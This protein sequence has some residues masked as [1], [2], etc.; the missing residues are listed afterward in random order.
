MRLL[1]KIFVFN[2]D[3]QVLLLQRSETD[4]HRP[5]GWDLP[6]GGVELNENPNVTVIRELKEE[7]GLAC[8]DSHIFYVGTETE[9]DYTVTL[10][11]R[12]HI[13]GGKVML[14]Y[15]HSAYTWV[16]PAEIAEVDMPSKYKK[17]AVVLA[18]GSY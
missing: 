10:L 6:G 8:A 9:P 15:E 16:T 2:S 3:G 7:A 17:A 1:A 11:Y 13:S 12:G 14:S 5:L 4:D 18:A